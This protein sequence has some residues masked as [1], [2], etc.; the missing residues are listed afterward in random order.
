MPMPPDNLRSQ[1][2]FRCT[3][4][5]WATLLVFM[6]VRSA[7]QP[8]R[9]TVWPIFAHAGQNWLHGADLYD[10]HY[11]WIDLDQYRYSPLVTT[12]F[13]PLSLLHL[14][15]GN[16]L[17][18]L[19]NMAAFFAGVV[20][21]CRIVYPG[22]ERLSW[23]GAACIGWLLVP[24]SLSSLNNGQANPLLIGALLLAAVAVY[25]ERW[26][27][28]A[29][30][31]AVAI[32]LKIYP[33]AIAMLLLLVYPRQL[34][35]RLT[36][37]LALGLLVPFC[38]QNPAYVYDQ[39]RQWFAY[40]LDEDRST[41]L[42]TESYRDFWILVRWADIPLPHRAYVAL[43]LTVAAA[44]A[45]V[46]LFGR[47]RGWPARDLLRRLLDLGCCWIIVFGPATENCTFILIAPTLAL[48]VWEAYATGRPLWTRW[49]LAAI[50]GIFVGSTL[51]TALPDGR[52]WVYPL[53]PLAALLL[54]GE[55]LASLRTAQR[56]PRD[57]RLAVGPAQAA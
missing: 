25:Q 57:D 22:S 5:V 14:S 54:F 4:A 26:N 39:Y 27:W 15:A 16:V 50:V 45:G 12:F 55:R 6:C 51:V 23:L 47:L 1:R 7:V 17:W 52:N 36:V 21:F 49:L 48:A 8:Q 42:I 31:L 19:V 32:L 33:V 34:G 46:V 41:R 24:L 43:Q 18:R 29:I 10:D 38:L 56:V 37:V 30:A 2:F 53:N 44:I 11:L 35:W 20:A 9:A 28:A 13:V 3:L 40:L